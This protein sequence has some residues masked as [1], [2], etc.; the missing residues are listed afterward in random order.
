[1]KV[2]FYLHHIGDAEKSAVM[3]ALS[4]PILST[5]ARVTEFERRFTEV[6]GAG[7]TVAVQ[8]CTAALHVCLLAA[9]VGPGDEVIVPPL[10]FIATSNAV[11]HCGATPIFADVDPATGNLDPVKARAAVTARTKAIIPVHLYGTPVDADAFEAIAKEH[12]LA[13]IYDAAHCVEGTYKGRR[14]GEL[15]DYVCYSFYATKNLT[16]GEG[17]AVT[18]RDAEKG[19]RVRL[20]VMHGMTSGGASRFQGPY[21]HWD[22]VELGWK[23]NFPNVLAAMLIPQLERL[24][25]M[26]QRR[27]A[28]AQRYEAAFSKLP[29]LRLMQ[30]PSYAK[31]ARHLFTLVFH[32]EARDEAIAQLNAAG[33]GITVNYRPVHLTQWYR[34]KFGFAPGAFP[35]AE[36]IGT[37]TLSIPLYPM[38][39]DESVETVIAAVKGLQVRPL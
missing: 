17:G 4:E 18:T 26:L 23:Y 31:S 20:L 38:M 30:V 21:K 10:T 24:P 11:L 28:I 25:A 35:H 9:G 37:G 39:S 16:S 2:P 15:G 34:E 6:V 14:I 27:E 3:E 8:H 36:A 33:I 22:M 1:M 29:Y 7:Q 13:L 32:P 5:G 12:K 19:A